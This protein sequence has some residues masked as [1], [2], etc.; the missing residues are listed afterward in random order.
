MVFLSL[1]VGLL[2]FANSKSVIRSVD[3]TCNIRVAHE[4]SLQDRRFIH[5]RGVAHGSDRCN[6]NVECCTA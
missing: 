3:R 1:N 2:T 6:G 5:I 4:A